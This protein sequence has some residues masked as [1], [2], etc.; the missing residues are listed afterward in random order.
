[1]VTSAIAIEV[2][3]ATKLGRDNDQRRLQHAAPLEIGDQ[4]SKR[5]IEDRCD[6]AHFV[7]QCFVMIPA[8]VLHLDETDSGFNQPTGEQAPLTE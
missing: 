4:R 7:G 6:V 1:M 8:V 3:L 5:L 2:G